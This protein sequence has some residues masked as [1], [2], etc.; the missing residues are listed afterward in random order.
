MIIVVSKKD[1]EQTIDTCKKMKQPVKY[2]GKIT[3]SQKEVEFN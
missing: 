1:L 3:D 2:L